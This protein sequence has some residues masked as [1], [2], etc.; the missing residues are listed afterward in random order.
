MQESLWAWSTSCGVI[1]YYYFRVF[2]LTKNGNLF[3]AVIF[4]FN[5]VDF[6][7]YETGITYEIDVNI[8]VI[9]RRD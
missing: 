2:R 9:K 6:Q 7:R 5:Y 8:I 3:F 4:L 1:V